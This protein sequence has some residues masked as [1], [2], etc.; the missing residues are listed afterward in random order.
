MAGYYMLVHC[1]KMLYKG[2]ARFS[3]LVHIRVFQDVPYL[4]ISQGT[5]VFL[6][7]SILELHYYHRVRE[8]VNYHVLSCNSIR[9]IWVLLKVISYKSYYI[10]YMY[11][12]GCLYNP[13]MPF[14]I[15]FFCLHMISYPVLVHTLR[16]GQ[17]FT[18]C[19]SH[20]YVF[21]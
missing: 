15:E 20:F 8:N 18:E 3:F 2:F 12:C 1:P 17:I 10:H 7:K 11:M 21:M 9:V 13:V 16:Q 5:A 19:F 6:L 14:M 4:Y